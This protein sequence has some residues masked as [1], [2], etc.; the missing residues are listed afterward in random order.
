[1]GSLSARFGI[2]RARRVGSD[3]SVITE[4]APQDQGELGCIAL[5]GAKKS[6]AETGQRQSELPD[7]EEGHDRHLEARDQ[8]HRAPRR[9]PPNGPPGAAPV[10]EATTIA[11]GRSA[12]TSPLCGYVATDFK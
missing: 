12:R 11:V 6:P 5:A 10:K 2:L 4:F 8:V 9:P 3:S 1:L 7:N